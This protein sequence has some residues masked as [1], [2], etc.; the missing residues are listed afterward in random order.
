MEKIE[1]KII[2]FY[3]TKR[4]NIKHLLW[5]KEEQQLLEI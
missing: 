3:K 2:G 4:G 1:N 5:S